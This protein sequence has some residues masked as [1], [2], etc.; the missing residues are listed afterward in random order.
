M[1]GGAIDVG[2]FLGN[3]GQDLGMRSVHTSNVQLRAHVPPWASVN[4]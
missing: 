2:V 4:N 3:Y 1:I